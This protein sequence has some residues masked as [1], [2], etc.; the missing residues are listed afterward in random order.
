MN[1]VPNEIIIR[2]DVSEMDLIEAENIAK[3]EDLADTLIAL[4]G[5][6]IMVELTAV[7]V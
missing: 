2:I 1:Y 3:N 4:R 7:A 6:K 5:K